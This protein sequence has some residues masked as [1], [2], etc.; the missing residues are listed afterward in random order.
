MPKKPVA[1]N[2]KRH[3]AGK[4]AT[5]KSESRWSTP[6]Q[7]TSHTRRCVKVLLLVDSQLPRRTQ[8]PYLI[9]CFSTK[10]RRLALVAE[11]APLV[12]ER[13]E[14]W[15]AK[16]GRLDLGTDPRNWQRE[17]LEELTDAR[18][19]LAAAIFA[20]AKRGYNGSTHQA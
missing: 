2:A 9:T 17:S 11:V 16:Y 14:M 5:V 10:D 12:A 18:F 4:Y 3:P 6:S 13:L 7:R 8:P 20:V 1:V 19:Y 15:R